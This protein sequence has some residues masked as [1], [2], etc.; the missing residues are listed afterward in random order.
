M[1]IVVAQDPLTCVAVGGGMCLENL[2][3]LRALLATSGH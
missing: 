3:A 1:P 2:D